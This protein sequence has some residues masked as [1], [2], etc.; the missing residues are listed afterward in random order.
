MYLH[1]GLDL[2]CGS[3]GSFGLVAVPRRRC[4]V[5]CVPLLQQLLLTLGLP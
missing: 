2:G 3:G 4:T 1:V 5:L